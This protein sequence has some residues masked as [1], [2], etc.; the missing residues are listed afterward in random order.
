MCNRWQ[1]VKKKLKKCVEIV[2]KSFEKKR[3]RL[4][5]RK[6]AKITWRNKESW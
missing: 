4:T 6:E 3:R 1:D 5:K 2:W